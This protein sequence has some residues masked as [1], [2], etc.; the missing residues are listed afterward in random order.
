MPATT[1]GRRA[2]ITLHNQN[3]LIHLFSLSHSS[4]TTKRLALSTQDVTHD[5]N[6]YTAFNFEIESP[7]DGHGIPTGRMRIS[8]VTREV[9]DL[10]KTVEEDNPQVDLRQV[11][12]DDTETIQDQWQLLDV[13]RITGTSLALEGEFSHELYANFPYPVQR[14][15][16]SKFYWMNFF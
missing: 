12:E 13:M 16:G 14:V 15:I 5:G 7:T 9:W 1:A 10:L 2:V 6:T 8:N 3:G 11:L 4:F